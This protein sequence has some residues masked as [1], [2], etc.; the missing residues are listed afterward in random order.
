MNQ[1]GL[2]STSRRSAPRRGRRFRIILRAFLDGVTCAG[3][4]GPID[5]PGAPEEFVDSRSIEEVYAS[6][7]LDADYLRDWIRRHRSRR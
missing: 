1:T 6:G 5:Y 2:N 3:L 7:E 4:F